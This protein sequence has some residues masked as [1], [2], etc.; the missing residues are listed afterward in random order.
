MAEDKEYFIDTNIFLRTLVK[1]NEKSFSECFSFLELVKKKKLK[2][3]TSFLVLA[4]VNWTLGSFYKFSKDETI[5][6][7]KS[8]VNLKNLKICDGCAFQSAVA[9]YEA[10]NIKFVD[11]L[12]A[13]NFAVQK[14]KAI[15]VSYDK[16]FD[17]LEATRIEPG[18][19][20]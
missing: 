17:K 16:D 6:A 13:S 3:C 14:R 12:I 20:I 11:A 18:K 19:F 15:I 7:I 2:A 8:I 5:R 9:L 4:E 1:E 10:H